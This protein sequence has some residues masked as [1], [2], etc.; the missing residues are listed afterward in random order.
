MNFEFTPILD[1]LN[2]KLK[3]LNA[4]KMN[5]YEGM[6]ITDVDEFELEGEKCYVRGYKADKLEKLSFSSLNFFGQMRA[7]V[8]IITPAPEYDIP[9]Y[10]MDW[11]ESEEHIFFIIDLMPA[12]DPGRSLNYLDN[13][14]Y[15]NLEDL[16]NDYSTI[17][18]LGKPSVFHWVRAIHSPYL[19]VGTVEKKP[20]NVERLIKCAKDYLD[21]WLKL[22]KEAKPIDSDPEYM[23]LIAQRRKTIRDLY[24]E[25]DPG[26]G[27][28][29]KFLGEEKGHK[30]LAVIE[31]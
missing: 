10:V 7:D 13:Y 6:D 28:I 26:V 24:R 30:A 12:D 8:I 1:I 17:P 14:L 16:Y 27:P 25:Y 9:Y 19:L 4:V 31:P 29:T 22:Y 5:E 21:A 15:K 20:E 23:K 3:D 18:G 2:E 11:D